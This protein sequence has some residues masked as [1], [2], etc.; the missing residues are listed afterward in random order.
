MKYLYVA[1]MDDVAWSFHHIL[2]CWDDFNQA[3]WKCGSEGKIMKAY[4]SYRELTTSSTG[5]MRDDGY[6]H[7][8]SSRT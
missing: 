2:Q 3:Q 6:P 8:P 4:P 1:G 7:D 5:M